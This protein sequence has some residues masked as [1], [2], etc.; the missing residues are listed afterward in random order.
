MYVMVVYVIIVVGPCSGLDCFR[1][2][3]FVVVF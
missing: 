1:G 3:R 2:L